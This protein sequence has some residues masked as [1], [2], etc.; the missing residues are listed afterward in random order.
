MQFDF[1]KFDAAQITFPTKKIPV[2]ELKEFFPEGQEPVWIIKALT[3]HELAIVNESV[4]MVTRTKAVIDAISEGSNESIKRGI[5]TLIN[6]D[7]EIT[8]EDLARRHRMLEFGT[9]SECPEHLCVKLAHAKPT[10]FY[11]L[12]N[13]IIRM[14]GDG[15]S[16]GE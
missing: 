14:T 10:I 3:G 1:D 13:E 16:L 12:T 11:R 4:E 2:P 15:A 8:P 9:V 5:K 6:R 7:G